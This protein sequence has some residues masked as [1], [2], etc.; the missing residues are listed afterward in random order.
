MTADDAAIVSVDVTNTGDMAGDE[1]VQLYL[2]DEYCSVT[3]PPK[4]LKGFE[5]VTLAVGETKT[6]TFT[7]TRQELQCLDINMNWS[8]EP[9]EFA[10]MVGGSLDQVLTA[11]LNIVGM[12][13][14]QGHSR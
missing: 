13:R 9:G 2:R 5:R 3:R 12:N 14:L 4:L 7:L 11:K 1:V 8:V 6:V 10:V